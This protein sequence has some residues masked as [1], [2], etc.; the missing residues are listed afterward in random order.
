M[1][2][3]TRK[4]DLPFSRFYRVLSLYMDFPSYNK[5]EDERYRMKMKVLRNRRSPRRTLLLR[6]R[7]YEDVKVKFKFTAMMS[8]P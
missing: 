6:D 4:S 8:P 2:T 3:V 7:L 5:V 1:P